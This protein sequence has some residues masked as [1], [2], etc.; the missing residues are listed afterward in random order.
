[1]Y[2][3]SQFERTI[4]T[5]TIF[6]TFG[7]I[8]RGPSTYSET[9]KA[10]IQTFRRLVID[11]L[12]SHHFSYI[13][14]VEDGVLIKELLTTLA[15]VVAQGEDEPAIQLQSACLIVFIYSHCID[16]DVSSDFYNAWRVCKQM[17]M[18]EK[19]LADFSL[20]GIETG[21]LPL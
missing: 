5:L 19:A 10:I 21:N 12:F 2:G 14:D 7:A 11:S 9:R 8:L 20:Q 6:P 4:L 16:Y 18:V 17:G 13:G 1:M 15:E 3:R